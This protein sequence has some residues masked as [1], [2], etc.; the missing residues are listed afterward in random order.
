MA[1]QFIELDLSQGLMN[2]RIN[3]HSI[4]LNGNKNIYIEENRKLRSI[5]TFNNI[6]KHSFG[7]NKVNGRKLNNTYYVV[8][9]NNINSQF[10]KPI[11]I[12]L[13]S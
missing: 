4:K 7:T 8:H 6:K 10:K 2:P 12:I 1:T 11:S 5:G 3:G 9:N 13:K